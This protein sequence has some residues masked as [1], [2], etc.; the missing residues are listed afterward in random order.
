MFRHPLPTRLGLALV[1]AAASACGDANLLPPATL[2]VEDDTVT[3][4]A[5]TGTDIGLPSAYDLVLGITARTDR[6]ADFD[7]VFDFVYDSLAHD[8]LPALLPRAALGLSADGGLLSLTTTPF[9]SLFASPSSG[10]DASK[11]V[12]VDSTSVVVARSRTQVCNFGITSGL[13]AKIQPIAISRTFRKIILHM[14]IDPNC[15]YHSFRPG[16]PGS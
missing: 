6:T 5:V 16:V 7:F 15:G 4:W 2:G 14:V 9:D 1:F 13:Y 8:S 12:F 10:Y 3:L 11:V